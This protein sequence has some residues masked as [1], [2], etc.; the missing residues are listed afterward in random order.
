VY[1]LKETGPKSKA[2]LYYGTIDC[3]TYPAVKRTRG[4]P[5]LID[6]ARPER[7]WQFATPEQEVAEGTT[8][9]R[10][11]ELRAATTYYYRLFVTRD[12][13]KSWDYRS[14]RFTTKHR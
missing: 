12:E 10:L 11:K 8:Q 2:V 4:S 13:G 3:L 6:M 1:E 14:R 7:T 9:F 5:V